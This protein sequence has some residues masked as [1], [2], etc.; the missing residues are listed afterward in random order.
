[1]DYKVFRNLRERA[2]IVATPVD[3]YLC[4][5]FLSDPKSQTEKDTAVPMESY[6]N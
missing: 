6:P 3:G 5:E 4:Y 2:I 1:M